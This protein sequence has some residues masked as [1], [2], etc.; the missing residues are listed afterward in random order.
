MGPWS[1]RCG[2]GGSENTEGGTVAGGGTAASESCACAMLAW[3]R[4]M[5]RHGDFQVWQTGAQV[6]SVSI[7]VHTHGLW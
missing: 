6:G 1:Q 4:Y 7:Q 2:A 3:H 5:S